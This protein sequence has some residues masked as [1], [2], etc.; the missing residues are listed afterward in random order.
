MSAIEANSNHPDEPT[1]E[2]TLQTLEDN[3]AKLKTRY[4]QVQQDQARQAEL[5]SCQAEIKN[6][7]ELKAELEKI[8]TE[9]S[10]LEI[11]LESELFSWES[12]KQ[13]FW[14]TVRFVGLGMAI[15]WGLAF[16]VMKHPVPGAIEP[17]RSEQVR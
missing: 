14:Q 2:Q 7:P 9:L 1:F 10:E 11:R 5:Q 6:Q 8:E 13:Y 4:S 16:Y 3:V 15:G 12:W 17:N